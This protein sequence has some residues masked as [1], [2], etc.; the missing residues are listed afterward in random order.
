MAN[1]LNLY[2]PNIDISAT[3]S[4]QNNLTP[5]IQTKPNTPFLACFKPNL[6]QTPQT[7]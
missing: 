2:E 4:P 3:Q 1:D 5:Q 6:T 7:A